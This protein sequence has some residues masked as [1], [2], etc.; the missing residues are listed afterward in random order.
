MANGTLELIQTKREEL[1][2]TEAE[3]RVIASE[4]IPQRRFGTPVTRAQQQAIIQRRE[5]AQQVLSEVQTAKQQ[6]NI[7]EQQARQPQENAE[8]RQARF[9]EER[10]EAIRIAVDRRDIFAVNLSRQERNIAEQLIREQTGGGSRQFQKIGDNIFE[11]I[12]TETQTKLVP[13]R[14]PSEADIPGAVRSTKSGGVGLITGEVLFPA[15]T[16]EGILFVPGY[17]AP[18]IADLIR[19]TEKIPQIKDVTGKIVYQLEG[20]DQAGVAFYEPPTMGFDAVIERQQKFISKQYQKGGGAAFFTA[21]GESAGGGLII[22]GASAALQPKKT[23]KALARGAFETGKRA[24]SGRG[25]PEISEIIRTQP[26]RAT[27]SALGSVFFFGKAGATRS[28]LK[29]PKYESLFIERRI[30]STGKGFESSAQILTKEKDLFST[31]FFLTEI[32]TESILLP[33]NDKLFLAGGKGKGSITKIK[34]FELGTGIPKLSK[35]IEFTSKDLSLIL[36]GEGKIPKTQIKLEGF[37]AITVQR[38]TFPEKVDSDFLLLSKGFRKDNLIF[39]AS[40]GRPVGRSPVTGEFKILKTGESRAGGITNIDEH[41]KG[42]EFR[43]VSSNQKPFTGKL[44]QVPKK[45]EDFSY[46]KAIEEQKLDTFAQSL[47]QDIAQFRKSDIMRRDAISSSA[48]ISVSE[49]FGKGLYERT[50]EVATVIPRQQFKISPKV[51]QILIQMPKEKQAVIPRTI[52]IDIEKEINKLIPRQITPPIQLT[53]QIQIPGLRTGL[54]PRQIT[55]PITK[56]KQPTLPNIP[57]IPRTPSR[58]VRILPPLSPQKP[59]AVSAKPAGDIN[60]LLRRFGKFRTIGKGLTASQ[61]KA[62]ARRAADL[63]LGRTVKFEGSPKSLR[64]LGKIDN[65]FYRL[66]KQGKLAQPFVF[67]ERSRF[68][69]STPEEIISIQSSRR[70]R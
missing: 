33:L 62:L 39:S 18:T 22:L 31:R 35:P 4:S 14:R 8:E 44:E 29:Y 7:A 52:L 19:P 17:K 46:L 26:G 10:R 69:L 55:P 41:L 47:T 65:R 59:F 25:F 40:V 68:A 50:Q 2:R 60:V 24:L 15:S 12:E 21:I 9:L 11:V 20:K 32:E 49:F 43:T 42:F 5:R 57:K 56:L 54:I 27:G 6:L 64:K 61:A 70:R 1:A 30:K 37:D 3:A 38:T 45:I 48:Q 28:I 13:V 58:P 36:T 16:E 53:P 66:P 34:S 51:E 23:K 67:V 63:T